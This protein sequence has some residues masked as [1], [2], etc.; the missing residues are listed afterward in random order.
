MKNDLFLLFLL[1]I[2][3]FLINY[4]FYLQREHLELFNDHFDKIILV[5]SV[6]HDSIR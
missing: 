2:I 3:L 4:L 5:E 6:D 1:I